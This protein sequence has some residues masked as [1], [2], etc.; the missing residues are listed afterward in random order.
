MKDVQCK[1]CRY[2]LKD[3]EGYNWCPNKTDDPDI[4]LI[5]DC[6]WYAVKTNADRI[7][8]MS[9]EEMASILTDDFC[10]LI[11]SSPVV[12]NGDCEVKMLEWLR[13]ETTDGG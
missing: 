11:C 12:C 6:E 7:R 8:S 4:D 10:E 5:R 3:K 1:K 9:D 13:Q 2:L